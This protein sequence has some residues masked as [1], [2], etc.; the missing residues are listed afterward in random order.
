M[1]DH[2][3]KQPS[4]VFCAS[5]PRARAGDSRVKRVIDTAGAAL[6]LV[7]VLPVMLMAALA[8]RLDSPGPIFFVQRRTGLNGAPIRVFKFRTMTV[9][10][11][12]EGVRH[13]GRVDHRVTRVG[14]FLRRAS[15]DE[16]PQLINVLKGEMSLVGPRPHALAHDRYYAAQVPAYGLR[17]RARPGITGLAQVTGYRG[18]IRSVDAMA[19]RVAADNL[20]IGQWS[21]WLD[22]KILVMTLAVG[23]F[24]DNAY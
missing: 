9:M 15:I 11:D 10:E 22:L 8:I 13:A 18:E 14:G 6:V 7:F 17:F 2:R 5:T 19:A 23:P 12:G 16:L 4:V 20:Y 3:T 1:T 21:L 24:H